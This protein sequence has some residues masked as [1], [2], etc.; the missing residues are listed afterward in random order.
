MSAEYF[1]GSD[2]GYMVRK[3]VGVLSLA[4]AVAFA[5]ASCGEN[6]RYAP[7]AEFHH[8]ETPAEM[9]KASEV[10]VMGR[11]TDVAPGRIVGAT[12]NPDDPEA[13]LRLQNVTLQVDAVLKGTI[14]SNQI[15]LEE[16]PFD[17]E[18]FS[19]YSASAEGDQGFYF[20]EY[21]EDLPPPFFRVVN[22]QGRFL[23][24]DG[25]V[26]TS[27]TEEAGW[28]RVLSRIS[29]DELRELIVSEVSGQP[30]GQRRHRVSTGE[31]TG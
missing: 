20:L 9:V 24:R 1:D 18:G 19:R 28:R 17:V 10:I 15:M 22:S 4:L 2:N 23:V 31:A 27:D 21:V 6:R 5:G 16:E 14:P 8:Y 7:I 11:V 29:P 12:T 30:R 26:V 3:S 25:K 13:V